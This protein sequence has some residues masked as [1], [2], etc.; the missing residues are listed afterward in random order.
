MWSCPAAHNVGT[1]PA[2]LK[3]LCRQKD[4]FQLCS[5]SILNGLHPL[6]EPLFAFVENTYFSGQDPAHL[7]SGAISDQKFTAKFTAGS[8]KKAF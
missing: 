6:G 1:A 5:A 7:D 2:A 3:G 4:T 8:T